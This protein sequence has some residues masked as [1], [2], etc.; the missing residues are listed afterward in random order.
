MSKEIVT[1]LENYLKNIIRTKSFSIGAL[2]NLVEPKFI[3]CGYR[4][5]PKLGDALNVLIIHDAAIG[6]FVLLSGAIREFRR[7]YPAAHITLMVN[8]G[9]LPLAEHCPYVDEIIVNDQR[10]QANAFNEL[11]AWNLEMAKKLLTRHYHICYAFVHRPNTPLLV[12]MSGANIRIAHNYDDVSRAFVIGYDT[13]K[14]PN[15]F[16]SGILFKSTLE[17]LMTKLLPMFKYGNHFVDTH[18]SFIDN[19]LYLPVENRELEL[20]Y[21]ALDATKAQE[22]IKTARRPLY[23]LAMG[24]RE[25]RKHYPPEKYARLVEMI[26]AEDS[27]ATFVILGAGKDD[28]HSAQILK[29]NLD[30]K[31]FNER[32]LN[33]TGKTNYRQSA[34]ILNFCEMYIGNDTGIMHVA[35]A[36][37]CPILTPNCFPADLPTNKFDYVRFFSPYKVPSV[38]VQP[39]H[40]LPECAVNK[41]YH[42]YGCHSKNPHCITQIAPEV[43]FNGYHL[44]K[45][46]IAKKNFNPTYISG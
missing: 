26:L 33:L 22:L 42:Q 7:I 19:A 45:E 34:A 8:N 21:T 10:Y 17:G 14:E 35:A 18:F 36:A 6:D 29:E 31:I 41:P 40:A 30:E 12:Y 28:L 27:A 9:S 15:A 39:A 25:L 5:A 20:W 3:E 4:T 24:G 11:Y 2:K 16:H 1:A 43:L 38:V 23:A 46:K 13:P 44:L 37:K 32:I